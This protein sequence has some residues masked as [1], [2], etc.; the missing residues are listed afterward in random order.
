MNLLYIFA[1]FVLVMLLFFYAL[2]QVIASLLINA[3]SKPIAEDQKE[4]CKRAL[5]EGKA[6]SLYCRAYIKKGKCGSKSCDVLK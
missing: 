6:G 1:G 3:S 2:Y 4:V 5:Q